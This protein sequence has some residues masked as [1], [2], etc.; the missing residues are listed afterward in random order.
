M[1]YFRTA[2]IRGSTDHVPFQYKLGIPSTYPEF[3]PAP[4]LFEAPSYHTAYDSVTMATNFTDPP[5]SSDGSVLPLHRLLVRLHFHLALS[6]SSA[7]RLPIHPVRKATTLKEAWDVLV[8]EAQ[9]RYPDLEEHYGIKLEYVTKRIDDFL[10][11]SRNFENFVGNLHGSDMRCFHI[12]NDILGRL[13]KQFISNVDAKSPRHVLVDTAYTQSHAASYF[14]RIRTL[15]HQ[16]ELGED[17]DVRTMLKS[18]K[19]E[20]SALVTAFNAAST[21]LRGGLFGSL[22]AYHAHLCY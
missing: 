2:P 18:L 20:L 19:V 15:L 4:P 13:S 12:Y 3:R 21:L 9:Q 22:D 11:A 14:P 16:L 5:C 6:F 1:L 8:S 17:R 7:R 10:N